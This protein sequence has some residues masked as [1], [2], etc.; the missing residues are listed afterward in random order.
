MGAIF[1]SKFITY[2][3]F[4]A[5]HCA[6][7]SYFNAHTVSIKAS[8]TERQRANKKNETYSTNWRSIYDFNQLTDITLH[9]YFHRR[10]AFFVCA[11]LRMCDLWNTRK[12][13]TWVLSLT[14]P[15]ISKYAKWKET[16]QTKRRRKKTQP[17]KTLN[18]SELRLEKNLFNICVFYNDFWH[19]RH[20]YSYNQAKCDTC[21][22]P[23]STI[24]NT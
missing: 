5:I 15:A 13:S 21:T 18:W 14:G 20:S 2:Q 17:K 8:D 9:H 7:H 12:K 4:D 22:Q 24:S 3:T 6:F 23:D 10:R 16:R 1:S 11:M 19:N